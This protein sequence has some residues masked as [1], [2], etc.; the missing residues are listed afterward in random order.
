VQDFILKYT[1]K[2]R[3]SRPPHRTPAAEGDTF[4]CTHPH[5][6]LPDAGAPPL[7]LGWL[8]PCRQVHSALFFKLVL[9]SQCRFSTVVCPRCAPGIGGHNA[10]FAGTLKKFRR[11]APEFV[12]PTSK[13]CRRLWLWVEKN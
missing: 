1:K 2:I 11:F 8:R 9:F 10:N 5:A 4:V 3:G 12:P 6:H 13:P 7:L